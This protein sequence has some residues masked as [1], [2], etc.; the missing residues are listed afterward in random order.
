MFN[1]SKKTEIHG[2]E[3]VRSVSHLQQ[4]LSDRSKHEAPRYTY[5]GTKVRKGSVL[6]H[7]ADGDRV[8]TF[9][10]ENGWA[11]EIAIIK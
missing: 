11:T 3:N 8:V 2:V 6:I 4:C 5:F 7:T 10:E 1:I 9:R